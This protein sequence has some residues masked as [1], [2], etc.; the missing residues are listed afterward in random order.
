MGIFFVIGKLDDSET[1]S[2]FGDIEPY[3]IIWNWKKVDTWNAIPKG[4]STN[5]LSNG[6]TTCLRVE[7]LG[8]SN[9]RLIFQKTMSGGSC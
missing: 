3:L 9:E 6:K 2:I 8:M 1:F 5:M 4:Q 7:G